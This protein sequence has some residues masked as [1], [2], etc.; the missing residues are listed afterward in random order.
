[1]DWI[2]SPC[3]SP[4]STRRRPEWEKLAWPK[5]EL[6]R[7]DAKLTPEENGAL[8]CLQLLAREEVLDL[9]KR[10]GVVLALGWMEPDLGHARTTDHRAGT[11]GAGNQR[12]RRGDGVALGGWRLPSRRVGHARP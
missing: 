11:L 7:S 1:M 2:R 6:G 5:G 10:V 4:A 3:R 8:L 12:T 9:C